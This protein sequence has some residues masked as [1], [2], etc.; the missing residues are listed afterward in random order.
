MPRK[1]KIS[2]EEWKDLMDK[3]YSKGYDYGYEVGKDYALNFMGDPM[4]WDWDRVPDTDYYLNYVNQAIADLLKTKSIREDM[5]R[6]TVDLLYIMPKFDRLPKS[7]YAMFF[8]ELLSE[9]YGGFGA[10]VETALEEWWDDG[11]GKLV[12]WIE[13]KDIRRG[14]QRDYERMVADVWHKSR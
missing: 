3:G 4:D 5:D 12:E 11:Y 6:L 8:G 7:E 9:M 1:N 10:G 13:N 14:E 2:K